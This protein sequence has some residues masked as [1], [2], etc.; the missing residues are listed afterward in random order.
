MNKN[1][2]NLY[3][4]RKGGV[5]VYMRG[6]YIFPTAS[7]N[8][9]NMMAKMCT[10]SYNVLECCRRVSKWIVFNVVVVVTPGANNL[11]DM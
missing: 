5:C 7:D 4:H 3:G 9:V 8:K 6:M 2:K 10:N 1:G 11:I